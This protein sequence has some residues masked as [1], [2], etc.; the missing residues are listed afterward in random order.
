MDLEGIPGLSLVSW[1]VTCRCN[2]RCGHCYA[3]AS[4]SPPHQELTPQEGLTLI[5]EL[6]EL[7]PGA[8][9]V[10]SGGEPLLRP[11]ILDLAGEASRRGLM[12]VLGTNGLY[13]DQEMARALRER[14]VRA[15]GISLDSPEPAYHD[16]FRGLP[17]A[18]EAALRAMEACRR[19]GLDYQVQT[20]AT[21]GNYHQLDRMMALARELGAKAFHLFFLVCTGRGQDMSDITPQQYEEALA[22]L[23]QRQGDYQPMM[24]RARCAPH[25]LRV[26]RQK[27]VG[28]GGQ[29]YQAGCLAATHYCRITCQ[30][31]VTPCP[32]LPLSAGELRRQSL[33]AIWHSAPLL[34]AMR[35]AEVGGKCRVCDFADLCQG[36]RARAYATSGSLWQEDPWCVYQPS[37]EVAT[38]RPPEAAKPRWT[39]EARA[40][41][42]K[43]PPFVRPMVS[44]FVE[45]YAKKKGL[46]VITLD[47][48]E[49]VRRLRK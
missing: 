41:M 49:E 32:Y 11:D 13:L 48:L 23:A 16:A 25:F 35:S 19:E 31:E 20:T 46:E 22:L 30:G 8:M 38:G 45:Q 10:L 24:V 47:L 15:V 14:G 4:E 18:W 27:G 17:G 43:A 12:V 3:S 26:A 1:N 29:G 9:L 5:R 39:P 37:Q 6:A 28:D 21:G 42:D 44:A 33:E 34:R 40:R 7:A 36:C 2:L